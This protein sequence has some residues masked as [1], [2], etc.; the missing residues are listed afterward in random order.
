MFICFTFIRR[1]PHINEYSP[2]YTVTDT[3]CK[4]YGLDICCII[5]GHSD[6]GR[7]ALIQGSILP[8]L[9]HLSSSQ[10]AYEV[11]GSCKI[12]KA[13]VHTGTYR[14]HIIDAGLQKSM[15]HIAR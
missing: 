13:L 6:V 4:K 2:R 11:F 1:F 12:L 15:E 5:A 3:D 7:D 10:T 9:M 8:E 14:Q